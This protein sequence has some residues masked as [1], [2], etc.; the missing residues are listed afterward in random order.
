MEEGLRTSNSA[1]QDA[2]TKV[3]NL[4]RRNEGSLLVRSLDSVGSKMQLITC[5]EDYQASAASKNPIYV[6]TTNLT[7]VLVVVRRS[8]IKEFEAG[9][10]LGESY[11]VPR[12]LQR[13]EEDNDFVCY[14]VTLVRVHLD[15]YKTQTK[16]KGW[17]VRDFKYNQTMREDMRNEA[18]ST[19]E[20]YLRECE[21]YKDILE[22]SFTHIA[23]TWI[24]L[25]ALRIFVES[26]LLYGIP[27]KF[28]TFLIKAAAKN[29]ARIHRNLEAVFGDGMGADDDE[30]AVSE[31]NE[32]HS[33]VSFSV[34]LYGLVPLNSKK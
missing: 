13:L 4:R 10:D 26:T 31:E 9:Y 34:N 15:E 5:L 18:K 20:S 19:V 24:H 1:F 25:R 27:P 21:R 28:Q 33:Y 6:N 32:Y 22:R 11:V 23:V 14:S 8:N 3:N 12:S 29:V 30:G 7:T 16:E 2:A 17:H